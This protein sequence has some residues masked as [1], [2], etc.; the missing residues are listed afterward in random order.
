MEASEIKNI[1]TTMMTIGEIPQGQRAEFLPVSKM[2]GYHVTNKIIT[3]K[4]IGHS[5]YDR[6]E[7]VYM[8]LDC[9]EAELHGENITGDKENKIHE[10]KLSINDLENMMYDGIY[11]MSTGTYSAVYLPGD[12]NI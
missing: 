4:S 9:E 8:F 1:E 12:I 11:N 10:I 3:D 5:C 6:E 2:I 7:G